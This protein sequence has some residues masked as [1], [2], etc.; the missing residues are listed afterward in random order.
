V[1]HPSSAPFFVALSLLALW[2]RAG[3]DAV[4]RS[5]PQDG[6]ARQRARSRLHALVWAAVGVHFLAF[7]MLADRFFVAHYLTVA[8]LAVAE[9]S[10]LREGPRGAWL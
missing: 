9:L 6:D 10:T 7:P 3:R 1:L 4:E 2:A 8:L 5:D